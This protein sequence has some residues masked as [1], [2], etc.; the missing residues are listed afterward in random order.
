LQ[1]DFTLRVAVAGADQMGSVP[2]PTRQA[3]GYFEHE[4][5]QDAFRH[6][7]KPTFDHQKNHGADQIAIVRFQYGNVGK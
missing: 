2:P 5:G 3:I 1:A 4:A 6:S 7:V